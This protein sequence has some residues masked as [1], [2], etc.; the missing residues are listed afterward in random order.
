VSSDALRQ[1]V[2]AVSVLDDVDLEP[3]SSGVRLSGLRPVLVRWATLRRAVGGDP[4][5]AA[6]R[7][8]LRTWLRLRGLVADLGDEAGAVL[9]QSARAVA[10]PVGHARHLGASWVQDTLLGGVLELGVGLLGVLDDPDEVVPLPPQIAQLAGVDPAAWWP[11][12]RGHADAMGSLA[13]HRLAR[14][15]A[16][17]ARRVLRPVG[18]CDVPTL[19]ASR[20]LREFLVEG[21]GCGLRALA[22]PMRNRG[23][24]DLAR[25]DPA[26]VG[27][28]WSA[29]DEPERGFCRPLLVTADE[30]TLAAADGDTVAAVLADPAGRE[31]A[32]R[33][34]RYR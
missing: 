32:L 13:A 28:A 1:A 26:F 17:L 10:A 20:P 22:V 29:T 16:D 11:R 25:I 27:A 3:R 30:V 14:D 33:D 2:L 31:P 18:G 12:L 23:W 6:G 21:D 19:L 5:S 4:A 34:V 24:Y 8:R 9:E 15:G 7:Y